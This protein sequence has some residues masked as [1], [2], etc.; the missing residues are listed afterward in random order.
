MCVPRESFQSEKTAAPIILNTKNHACVVRR[1]RKLFV[2]DASDSHLGGF[3][4]TLTE[5]AAVVSFFFFV[6]FPPYFD[7]SSPAGR[8][9]SERISRTRPSWPFLWRHCGPRICR[10]GL[11]GATALNLL[12]LHHLNHRKPVKQT[13]TIQQWHHEPVFYSMLICSNPQSIRIF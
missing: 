12:A 6:S 13:V 3:H 5:W 11:Q 8:S 7:S 2:S 1:S 10:P 9:S 4:F